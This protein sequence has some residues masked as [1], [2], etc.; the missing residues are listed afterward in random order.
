MSKEQ[1]ITA[2]D[3][4]FKGEDKSVVWDIV[5]ANGSAQNMTG[6]TVTFNLYSTKSTGSALLTKT[7][8][9][10]NGDGTNDRA[11]ITVADTDTEPLPAGTYIY[12]L[13][14]SDAGSEQVLAYGTAILLTT[15][16]QQ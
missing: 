7:A 6:W 1:N 14:R 16:A 11:T 9:L 13:V 8:A 10:S 12:E 4:W 3:H 15:K 2:A 5:D